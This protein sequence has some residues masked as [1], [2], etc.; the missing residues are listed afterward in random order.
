MYLFTV[1]TYFNRIK[2]PPNPPPWVW[3][4]SGCLWVSLYPYPAHPYPVTH[5]GFQT[6]DEHYIWE[7]DNLIQ[8]I[9]V[10]LNDSLNSLVHT[11]NAN[12]LHHFVPQWSTFYLL[13]LLDNS[14]GI[15]LFNGGSNDMIHP[16]LYLLL[17]LLVSGQK[18][19]TIGMKILPMMKFGMWPQ[20]MNG[21]PL[22]IRQLG[23][24]LS[25]P[26][27]RWWNDNIAK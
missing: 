23:G 5:V 19:T 22:L 18:T 6:C 4:F 1:H 10:M 25:L 27:Y 2:N 11:P 21:R 13:F 14:L 7:L 20:Q 3:V 26:H 24:H 16:L 8:I 12:Y 9:D 17:L 15:A